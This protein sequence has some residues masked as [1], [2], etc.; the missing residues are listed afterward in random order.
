[1]DPYEYKGNIRVMRQTRAEFFLEECDRRTEVISIIGKFSD[2]RS[3]PKPLPKYIKIHTFKFEDVES[4]RNHGMKKAQ[5]I[6]MWKIIDKAFDEDKDILIH[7]ESGMSR[8]AA[9]GVAI[10]KKY[11]VPVLFS[12]YSDTVIHFEKN[13]SYARI[14][15]NA[16]CLR[17]MKYPRPFVREW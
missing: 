17:C 3:F 6:R 4:S 7:C 8:S 14:K 2:R 15:P 12:E 11:G 13:E 9:I 5:A 10:G 1:M 16:H